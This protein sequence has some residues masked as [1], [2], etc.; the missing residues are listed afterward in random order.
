MF[1]DLLR[2]VRF[3]RKYKGRLIG[4]ITLFFIAR[5]FEAAVPLCLMVGI[6]RLERGEADLLLPVLGIVGAVAGSS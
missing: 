1:R 4:G 2:L 3:I 5:L 6:N